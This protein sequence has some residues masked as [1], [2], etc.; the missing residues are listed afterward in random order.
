MAEHDVLLRHTSGLTFGGARGEL[1]VKVEGVV[2]ASHSRFERGVDLSPEEFLK[3]R[4]WPRQPFESTFNSEAVHLWSLRLYQFGS[5][6]YLECLQVPK[7][8]FKKGKEKKSLYWTVLYVDLQT[9][10]RL[11][12]RRV[13]IPPSDTHIPVYCGE[14]CVPLDLFCTIGPRSWKPQ[15]RKK[16]N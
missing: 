14:E 2:G 4:K 12:Q 1:C 3:H 8:L 10:F 16:Y 15:Y 6:S 11:S 9:F 5:A 7:I 13:L